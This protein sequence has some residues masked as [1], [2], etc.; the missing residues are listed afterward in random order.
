MTT[1]V[2]D[3]PGPDVPMHLSAFQPV[4]QMLHKPGIPFD[5]LAMAGR[6]AVRNGAQY[7]YTGNGHNLVHQSTYCHVWGPR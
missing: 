3:H 7:A 4:Y 6:V 1:W 5:T 2:L